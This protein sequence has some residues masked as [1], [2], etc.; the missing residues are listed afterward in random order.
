[1]SRPDGYRY[2][3]QYWRGNDRQNWALY[4]VQAG[5]ARRVGTA[6]TERDS[7]TFLFNEEN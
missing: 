3:R 4:E 1:M 6:R 7:R 5:T 2:I